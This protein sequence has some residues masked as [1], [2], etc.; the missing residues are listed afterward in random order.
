M[1]T[2]LKLENQSLV[3]RVAADLTSTHVEALRGVIG[4]SLDL[5]DGGTQKWNTFILDLSAA[6]MVDSV[7]LNFVVTLLKRVQ[8]RGAKM[9]VKY[10]S[11]DVMRTFA[12]TR[13]DQHVELVKV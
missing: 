8:K 9:Q 3:L 12:F 4:Q 10:S 6:K 11:Q 2:D 5:S 1:T 13:L 7:G